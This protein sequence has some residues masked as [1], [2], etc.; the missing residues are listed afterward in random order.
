MQGLSFASLKK[1]TALIPLFVCVGVGCVGS[2]FYLGRLGFR[3]PEVSWNKRGDQQP[4]N[5]YT[6]KQYKFY[7]PNVD[8]KKLESPAPKY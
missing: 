1:H 3:N 7:S 4:W 6:E 8:Y 2:I 5:E